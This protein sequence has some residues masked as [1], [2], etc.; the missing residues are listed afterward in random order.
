MKTI[1][2][3]YILGA[4]TAGLIVW[5]ILSSWNSRLDS[6]LEKLHKLNDSLYSVIDSTNIKIKELDSVANELE[7]TIES[8]KTKL[9][10]LSKKASEYKNKY[11]KEH[12]RINNLSNDDVISEF[13]NAFE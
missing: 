3:S 7:S 8:N 9:A 5:I 1:I 10:S 13:T 12:N 6:K 4:L 2:T 11:E